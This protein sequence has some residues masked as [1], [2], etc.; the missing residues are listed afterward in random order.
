[1]HEQNVWLTQIHYSDWFRSPIS[2]LISVTDS[3]LCDFFYWCSD[4][5]LLFILWLSCIYGYMHFWFMYLS[6][7]YM[8]IFYGYFDCHISFM[9]VYYITYII[10]TSVHS[11]WILHYIST[12]FIVH[13]TCN[14][15]VN[16]GFKSALWNMKYNLVFF[17]C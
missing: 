11:T 6:A 17:F 1:M 15:H 3:H 5:M 4:F 14:L 8:N 10:Y 13:T 9:T 16:V 12:S 7:F 2:V